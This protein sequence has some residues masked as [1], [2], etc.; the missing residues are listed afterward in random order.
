ME[1]IMDDIQKQDHSQSPK[2]GNQAW[3]FWQFASFSL[4]PNLIK[5]SDVEVKQLKWLWP[6]IIPEGCY[7][8]LPVSQGLANH[9]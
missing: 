8:N 5:A 7:V 9:S 1:I 3:Q 4:K 2:T 6:G